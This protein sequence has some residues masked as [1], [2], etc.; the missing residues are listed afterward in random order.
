V[1]Q[2]NPETKE[3][4]IVVEGQWVRIDHLIESLIEMR[5][6]LDKEFKILGGVR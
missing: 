1:A 2:Y 3:W 4:S 5:T 6:I